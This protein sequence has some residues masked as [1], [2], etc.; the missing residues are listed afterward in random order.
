MSVGRRTT[1]CNVWLVPDAVDVEG[2]MRYFDHCSELRGFIYKLHGRLF[3]SCPL[4]SHHLPYRAPISS[5]LHSMG[6]G[7][8]HPQPKACDVG[9]LIVRAVTSQNPF[10]VQV[11]L[12]RRHDR[13]V[14]APDHQR[15][16]RLDPDLQIPRARPRRAGG[17]LGVV[18]AP[19]R[20]AGR[21]RGQA[22]HRLAGGLCGQGSERW[23]WGYV[24]GAKGT[25]MDDWR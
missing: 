6:G 25:C 4:A 11:L 23:Q 15:L 20:W 22:R 18:R 1:H 10:L 13:R 17:R 19:R 7:G 12:C 3:T 24:A 21:E 14:D 9:C 8:R 5:V 2:S 16:K